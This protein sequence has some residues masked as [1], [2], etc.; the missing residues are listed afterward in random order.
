M[1][2]PGF[3]GRPC[4]ACPHGSYNPGNE[5]AD[6]HAECSA[7]PDNKNTTSRGNTAPDACLCVPGTGTSDT[8]ALAA[9]APCPI[10][11]YALGGSN[12]PCFSCG[13]GTISEPESGASSFDHCQCNHELG[14]YEAD[15]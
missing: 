2:R 1:C 11:R 6:T 15:A 5:L 12:I 9:C 7:C 13:F 8:A 10:G 3:G 14:L 4:E